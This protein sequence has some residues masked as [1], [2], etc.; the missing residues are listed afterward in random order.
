MCFFPSSLLLLRLL[1][2]VRESV[3]DQRDLP[4]EAARDTPH[5]WGSAQ[6]FYAL[7]VFIPARQKCE[8][9]QVMAEREV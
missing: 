3:E 5:L 6:T 9:S 8:V 4:A 2:A 7:V 1:E